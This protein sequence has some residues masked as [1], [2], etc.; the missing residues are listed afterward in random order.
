M[1]Y[2]LKLCLNENQTLL[3]EDVLHDIKWKQ[4]VIN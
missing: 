4:E 2:C 3:F 1:I